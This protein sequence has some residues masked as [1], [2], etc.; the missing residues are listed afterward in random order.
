M[1]ATSTLP[2]L[3]RA[4]PPRALVLVAFAAIYVIWGSTYLAIAVAVETVPPLLMVGLRFLAAG[5]LLLAVALLRGEAWPQ[6]AAWLASTRQSLFVLGAYGLLA[7]AELRVASGAAAVLSAT[8][9]MFVVLLDVRVRRRAA[10]RVGVGLGLLGVLLLS[11]SWRSGGGL[12]AWGSLA[13]L[14]SGL[15]WG[16][17]AVR[18]KA[19]V[20]PGST[21]M[22][23][24]MELLTG[25]VFLLGIAM[26]LGESGGGWSV[27]GRSLLALAYLVVFGSVVAY[28]AFHWLLQVSSPALVTTHAYVNPVIALALGA[29]LHGEVVGSTELA[30]TALVLGSVAVLAFATR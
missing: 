12:D 21:L 11:S 22:A 16:A 3:D 18:A 23:A 26:L 5:S 30:A 1:D 19:T 7:W 24:A 6:R 14:G 27:S 8:S 28:T 25:S 10:A 9:P 15:L 2:A 20:A 13:I 29:M 4:T 17:A